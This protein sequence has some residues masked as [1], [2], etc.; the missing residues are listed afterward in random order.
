MVSQNFDDQ[1]ASV[2]LEDSIALP[3]FELGDGLPEPPA[4]RS[5][6]LDQRDASYVYGDDH[7]R[8]ALAA[9]NEYPIKNKYGTEQA[10]LIEPFDHEVTFWQ[11]GENDLQSLFIDYFYSDENDYFDGLKTA[12]SAAQSN[13]D[14]S[15]FNYQVDDYDASFETGQNQV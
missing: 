14:N 9:E 15:I 4:G 10:Q 12:A 6:Y 5:P 1:V 8:H 13:T 2:H 11:L 3:P 7:S